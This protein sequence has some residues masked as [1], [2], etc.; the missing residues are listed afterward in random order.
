MTIRETVEE[1]CPMLEEIWL[2]SFP[3]T[4]TKRLFYMVLVPNLERYRI[5]QVVLPRSRF[6][7]GFIKGHQNS[8]R[9]ITDFE[10]LQR[11]G[12]TSYMAAWTRTN[13]RY[14]SITW[15]YTFLI[16]LDIL[17]GLC[18]C[19]G[20]ADSLKQFF[21]TETCDYVW[22]TVRCPSIFTPVASF[23]I[24]MHTRYLNSC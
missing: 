20:L 16:L 23:L 7:K 14:V 19:L 11:L 22:H 24:L 4:A 18:R 13:Q 12:R 21:H 9:T 5:V 8:R 10:L 6:H 2:Q 15:G 3:F 1:L 17:P